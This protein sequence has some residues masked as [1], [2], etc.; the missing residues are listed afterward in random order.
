LHMAGASK[1]PSL[2]VTRRRK[3]HHVHEHW[4]AEAIRLV[5]PHD[6]RGCCGVVVTRSR[7][8]LPLSAARRTHVCHT[9][10]SLDS[11]ARNFPE[12]MSAPS[13]SHPSQLYSKQLTRLFADPSRQPRRRRRAPVVTVETEHVTVCSPPC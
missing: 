11:T 9:L 5:K 13:R 12:K 1:S 10:D 4:A 2:I 8:S 7:S 3:M 6:E